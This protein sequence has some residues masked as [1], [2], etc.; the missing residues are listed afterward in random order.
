[1]K[2]KKHGFCQVPVFR[3]RFFFLWLLTCTTA[4]RLTEKVKPGNI[5]IQLELK[6]LF[7]NRVTVKVTAVTWKFKNFKLKRRPKMT[8]YYGIYIHRQQESVGLIIHRIFFHVKIDDFKQPPRQETAM[9]SP[10]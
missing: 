6:S 5:L 4:V 10:H 2:D 8:I 1:M 7:L 9:S 3:H